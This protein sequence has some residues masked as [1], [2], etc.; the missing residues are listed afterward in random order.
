[1][2]RL[3][4]EGFDV[5]RLEAPRLGPLHL[6]PDPID[7]ARVHRVMRECAFLE[8]ILELAPVERIGYHPRQPGTYFGLLAVADGLDQ[9]V[10]QRL[11][12]ELELAQH[13]EHLA[14]QRLAGLFQLV[15]ERAVH[16]AFPGL[17]GDEVP[18]VADLGLADAMDAPEALL[19]AVRIP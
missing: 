18:E 19:D 13:V 1:L 5:M 11:P 8:E 15:Q 16:V 7:A 6:L 2:K 14:S 10:A 9:Q 17:F 12:L 3:Q 4:K